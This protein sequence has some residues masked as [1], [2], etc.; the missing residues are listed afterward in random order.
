MPA[1]Q[2]SRSTQR[3]DAVRESLR[4][5]GGFGSAQDVY[6]ELRSAGSPI[7]L[8]TVYRHL[9]AL[10][11]EGT[12][13]T[14][15]S[16]DGEAMYRYCADADVAHHHHLVCRNCGKAVEVQGK[17]VENWA[18]AVAA[19]HGYTDVDHTVELFGL[20]ADCRAAQQRQRHQSQPGSSR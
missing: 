15:R 20:C 11:D 3:G 13:D 7:G 5:R 18:R 12:V 6:A 9:Q 19:E 2:R 1:G 16:A 14:I 4:G 8:A 17:A 10:V